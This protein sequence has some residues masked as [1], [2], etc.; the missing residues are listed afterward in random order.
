MGNGRRLARDP[1][2][3]Q[4]RGDGCGYL[5]VRGRLGVIAR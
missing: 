3:G 1:R 4:V 2:V 5:Q